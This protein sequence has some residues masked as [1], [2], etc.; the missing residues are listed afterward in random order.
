MRELT[1]RLSGGERLDLGLMLSSRDSELPELLPLREIAVGDVRLS[2]L[3][4]RTLDA[5]R[6][7]PPPPVD[8]PPGP[9][10][11][12]WTSMPADTRAG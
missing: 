7:D 4:Q 1:D 12:W 8:A 3:T 11:P 5:L 6:E 9:S 2:D 10:L